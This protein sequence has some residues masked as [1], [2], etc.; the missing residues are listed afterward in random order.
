MYVRSH[1][2]PA[3]DGGDFC[4]FN[5]CDDD[6]KSLLSNNLTL[7]IKTLCL[8]SLQVTLQSCYNWLSVTKEGSKGESGEKFKQVK[9]IWRSHIKIIIKGIEGWFSLL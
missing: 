1:S 2:T 7:K 8:R 9:V 6:H 3:T 4:V 5:A